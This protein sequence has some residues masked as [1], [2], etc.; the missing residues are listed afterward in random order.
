ITGGFG[1]AALDYVEVRLAVS[2]RLENEWSHRS[3]A[4]RVGPNEAALLVHPEARARQ[5]DIDAATATDV[6]NR[7]SRS[8]TGHAARKQDLPGEFVHLHLRRA[9]H[10]VALRADFAKQRGWPGLGCL[11]DAGRGLAD[12]HELICGKVGHLLLASTG[13]AHDQATHG[14]G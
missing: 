9:I 3:L 2:V 12:G 6:R 8:E 7:D 1:H 11:R 14:V 4:W 5:D 10:E 13:P